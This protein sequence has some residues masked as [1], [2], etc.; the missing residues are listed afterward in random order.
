[1][2]I[3][4]TD[5][6]T[7]LYETA[8][9][10]EDGGRWDDA[11]AAYTGLLDRVDE[12]APGL[13]AEV[14]R[15]TGNVHYYRGDLELAAQ[16]Y[17]ASC[18]EAEARGATK[19]LAS[20]LN[21]AAVAHQ[22]LGQ[23]DQA[24]SCYQRAFEAAEAV[25]HSRLAIMVQQ[26]LATIASVRGDT[27]VAL[28]H[29]HAALSR[30]EANNDAQGLAGVLNNIGM[31][32]V[33]LEQWA[34]AE[35][36]FE[37]ALIHA[38]GRNDTEVVGTIQLN[39]ADMFVEQDRF[40]DARL[41][42]DQAFELFGRLGSKLGLGEAFRVYGSI[43]RA[44]GKLQL[45]D[46]HLGAVAE[47][48]EAADYLLLHAE[49]LMEHALVFLDLGRN[50]DALRALNRAHA[51]FG[52]LRARRQL[53]DIDKRLDEL[54]SNYLYVVQVWAESIESKDH[55]TAGH[56]GRVADLTTRLAAAAGFTG[57]DLTWI[58]MGAFL[59]DVGK[60]EVPPD[61]LNKPGKLTAEEWILM[62]N[63]TT[64]GDAIVAELGFPWDIRPIVRNHHER[65][66]GTGYPD[67]LKGE[68]IPLAARILCIADVYDALT[69]TRSY[70][71]GF[72]AAKAIEVMDTEA[73]TVLDPKLYALFRELMKDEIEASVEASQAN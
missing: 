12:G 62:R 10:A 28:A 23:L 4:L 35:T 16:L 54:E 43:F 52:E 15:R 18:V 6:L 38:Q 37:R 29:Y 14:L 63:H 67:N 26:N 66:D 32:H 41:C 39:R 60:T 51:L 45:A 71:A 22:A 3:T 5:A 30:H 58:R 64:A 48:A 8:R 50:A 57:R 42:C 34:E 33:D 2:T 70:R 27:D 46:A 72:T 40:D 61:V 55:Y 25:G 1:M 53:L 7:P 13:K 47:I 31:V 20:A 17:R 24:E 44:A 68:E 21:G 59:H 9:A 65:Y 11:L 19:D 56:C 49:A 73:G 69:T 36:A